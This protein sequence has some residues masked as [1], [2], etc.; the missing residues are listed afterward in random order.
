MKKIIIVSF[1][2]LK[3]YMLHIKELFE[4]YCFT[5]VNYPLFRY[6]YDSND[7]MENYKEHM[8]EYIQSQNPDIIL[9]WFIDVGIDVFKYIKQNN[10]NKI[11]IM[12][13]SDDPVNINK[14]L[15]DKAKLFDIVVTPCKDTFHLYKLYSN[16]NKVVFGP[17][18]YDKTLFSKEIDTQDNTEFN[19]DISIITY[20]PQVIYKKELIDGIISKGLKLNLYGSP[21]FRELYP[22]NYKGEIPYY[23]LNTLFKSSKINMVISPFKDKSLYVNEYVIPILGSNGL[24]LHDKTKDITKLLE[25]N[26][27]AILYDETDYLDKIDYILNNYDKMGKI[28]NSAGI[29]GE[30]YSWDKWVENIVS[31]IGR[32][33]FNEVIYSELYDLDKNKIGDLLNYWLKTGIKEKQICFDFS[34]PN[35]FNHEDYIT[36]FNLKNNSKIAYIHWY[37]NSQDMMYMKKANRNSNNNIDTVSYNIITED[38]YTVSNIFNKILKFNTTELGLLELSAFCDTVPY[39]KINEILDSY[40]DSVY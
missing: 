40:M 7:K 8:N 31:E 35:S 32:M 26:I 18:G 20:N 1:Y 14:E 34:V 36:K 27:N 37:I 24:L 9:W 15:F 28:K 38:Y 10:K 4:Q 17:M 39:I 23:K 11:F 5:V 2:E 6:A 13:N 29:I 3:D 22:L 19:C 30:G 16:V 12:Y 33:T 21:I 25:H